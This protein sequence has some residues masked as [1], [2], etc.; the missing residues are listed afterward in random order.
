MLWSTSTLYCLADISALESDVRIHIIPTEYYLESHHTD[1]NEE[2]C[3]FI[4]ESYNDDKRFKGA[5]IDSS[6]LNDI[7]S[8]ILIQIIP[9]ITII[10][11]LFFGVSA[12]YGSFTS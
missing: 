7:K 11:S 8:N 5:Y 3:A 9:N 6:F 12:L 1:V 10:D 4:N 2:F